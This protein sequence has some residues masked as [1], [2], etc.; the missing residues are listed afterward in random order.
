MRVRKDEMTGAEIEMHWQSGD[1]VGLGHRVAVPVD[2][3]RMLLEGELQQVTD[4]GVV[5]RHVD[6]LLGRLDKAELAL[7]GIEGLCGIPDSPV[8]ESVAE[9]WIDFVIGERAD[10]HVL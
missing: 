8:A 5:V 6:A 3:S 9:V 10:K 4:R 1:L 2:S 7:V